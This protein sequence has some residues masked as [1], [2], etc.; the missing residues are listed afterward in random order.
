MS[1]TYHDADKAHRCRCKESTRTMSDA[2]DF[3]GTS[4]NVGDRIVYP[5]RSGSSLWM[6]EAIVTEI[7]TKED[8]RGRK[9]SVLKAQRVDRQ[10]KIVSIFCLSRVVCIQV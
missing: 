10:G 8:W 3:R 1:D 7:E 5:G 6:N 2:K 9:R 4:I